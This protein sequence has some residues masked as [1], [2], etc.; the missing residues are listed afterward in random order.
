M[1]GNGPHSG[2]RNSSFA[3]ATMRPDGFASISGS[4]RATTVALRCTGP[5]LVVSADVKGSLKVGVPGA[6]GLTAED[7]SP[8]TGVANDQA[9]SFA[10][11]K[12]LSSLVGKDIVL[13]LVLENANVFTVGFRGA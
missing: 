4:G 3:L 1:G 13:E 11:Q 8:V 7:A 9:V 12:N 6:Y 5:T 2:P 10:S